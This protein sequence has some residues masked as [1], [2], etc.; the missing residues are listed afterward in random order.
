LGQAAI[1]VGALLPRVEALVDL[2]QDLGH[3]PASGSSQLVSQLSHHLVRDR[4]AE[5]VA[6]DIH[7]LKSIA[8]RSLSARPGDQEV[9]AGSSRNLLE[10]MN[11]CSW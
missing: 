4:V 2:S 10:S 5:V 7:L 3:W 9:E 11:S 6:A 1:L 8:C